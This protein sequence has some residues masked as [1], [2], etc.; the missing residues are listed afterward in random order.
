MRPPALYKLY[1]LAPDLSLIHPIVQATLGSCGGGRL[2]AAVSRAGG[3]GCLTVDRTDPEVLCR[4]LRRIRRCT[5]R[6]VLLA[7]AAEWERDAVLETALHEGFRFVQVFWWNGER[8]APRIRRHGGTVFW[9]VGTVSQAHDAIASGASVL[10]VQ[11]TE[12]GGQVRSPHRALDLVAELRAAVGTTVPLIVGG[13]FADRRDVSI[14]LAAGANAAMFGTR[15]L[16]SEEANASAHDKALLLRA[17]NDHLHLDTRL[18]GSWPCA[19]RRR[20]V[21]ERGDDRP[22]LFAGLGLGRIRTIEPASV[23]VRTL[24]PVQMR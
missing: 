14:A 6:P 16:L 7:F 19:P 17:N 23:L 24:S 15:F 8:L 10:V 5:S 21:T 20:L 2:A 13:G 9:Q 18:I 4:I 22:S 12:A 11:G 1:D 3:L